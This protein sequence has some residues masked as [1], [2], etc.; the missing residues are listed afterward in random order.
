MRMRALA[1]VLILAVGLSGCAVVVAPTSEPNP[2][3]TVV[4]DASV[5]NGLYEVTITADE[6][7]AGGVDDPA[8]IAEYAGLYYWEF[9][10]GQW[11]YDQTSDLPLE[12]PGGVGDYTLEGS[13]YTHYWGDKPTDITTATVTVL[14][15]GSLQFTEIVDGDPSLQQVSDVTFGL[16]PW[17]RIGD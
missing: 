14:P 1:A 12:N 2:E 4:D 15:D 8:L 3:P 9:E 13:D 6:L 11:N 17:V 10:D 16:H 5:L 7:A